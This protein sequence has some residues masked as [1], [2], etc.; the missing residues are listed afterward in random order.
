MACKFPA[1]RGCAVARQDSHGRRRSL[2]GGAQAPAVLAVGP[3]C[4]G[5]RLAQVHSIGEHRDG[6]AGVLRASRR[7]PAA[8]PHLTACRSRNRGNILP[9]LVFAEELGGSRLQA[10]PSGQEN[11]VLPWRVSS[12]RFPSGV[13]DQP[14]CS[15]PRPSVGGMWVL[16][17]LQR[18][19]SITRRPETCAQVML[20]P[21][22]G[23][24]S[25][26]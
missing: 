18:E 12:N 10:L 2:V 3:W 8:S 23:S 16:S 26:V 17:Y 20:Q 1:S 7:L 19:R 15:P 25:P 6:G 4:L 21:P 13:L 14:Q 22:G 5:V 11:P 9:F 24:L